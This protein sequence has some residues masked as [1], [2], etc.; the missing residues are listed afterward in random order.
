MSEI[1][2]YSYADEIQTPADFGIRRDG[3]FDAVQRAVAGVNYYADVVGFGSSSG[4]AK[5]QG[6]QQSPLG[7]R[8]FMKTG[9]VC[10]NGANMY[11]YID[12]I[13]TGMGISER[14][15]QSLKDNGLPSLQGLAPGILEDAAMALNPVPLFSA[16]AGS[17]Y[18]KCKKVTK[19]VGDVQGR[20]KSPRDP[21]NVWIK[22]PFKMSGGV[23]QQSRWVF[24]SWISAEEY[25]AELKSQLPDQQVTENFCCGAGGTFAGG[26]N[27][28]MSM[29][30]SHAAAVALLGI[31][32]GTLLLTRSH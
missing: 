8:F 31:L 12:T 15:K 1:P 6:F 17:G 32:V 10:S 27:V 18:A 11:E 5:E 13:P 2:N 29:K 20:V 4:L 30:T 25:E 9:Q 16:V 3:S 14:T 24:D 23:P 28:A 21:S 22:D 19:P 7:I 26:P